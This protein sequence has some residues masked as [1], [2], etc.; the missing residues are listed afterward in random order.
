[1][2][3]KSKQPKAKLSQKQELLKFDQEVANKIAQWAAAGRDIVPSF[4]THEI[5]QSHV[6]GLARQNEHTLFWEHH[7]YK[8]LR[9]DVGRYITKAY[10]KEDE[11]KKAVLL[12][13]FEYVQQFYIVRRGDEDVAVAP[14][15]MS[16]E[17]IDA[18]VQL[19]RRRGTACFAHAD[20][21]DRYKKM[22]GS[23]KA[24]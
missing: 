10:G 13:G 16:D 7:T 19:L 4:I 8:S 3:K 1:M 9:E 12:P 20:E 11:E 2:S 17:E 5:V 15:A 22:R 6:G 24:A 21:F 23:S 18:K 14:A